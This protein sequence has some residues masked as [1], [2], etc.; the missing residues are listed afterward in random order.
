[1]RK[2]I[3]LSA[4]VLCLSVPTALAQDAAGTLSAR[5]VTAS[6]DAGAIDARLDDVLPLFKDFAFKSFRLDD[7]A[8]MAFR[9]GATTN[10]GKV[11]SIE[12]TQ[13]QE[14][15]VMVRVSKDRRDVVKTRLSLREDKP[16]VVGGFDDPGGGKTI[17]VL[18]L[19]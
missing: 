18:K 1:M 10:L 12:L 13:V 15:N 9:E 16:V 2:T 6:K 17:I 4:M 19:K 14:R 11:Y 8:T 7:E 3:I 5:L